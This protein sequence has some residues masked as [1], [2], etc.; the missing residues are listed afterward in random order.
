MKRHD[1]VRR[2][3]EFDTVMGGYFY[4]DWPIHWST[5]DDVYAAAFAGIGDEGQRDLRKEVEQILDTYQ[6]D[7]EVRG[8]LEAMNFESIPH[9][10]LG[11]PPRAW[12]EDLLDRLPGSGESV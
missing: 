6:T 4:E 5:V 8:L 12:L 11:L 10:T 7:E 3:E 9:E 2:Y 1:L